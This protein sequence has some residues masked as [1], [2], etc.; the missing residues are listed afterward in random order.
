VSVAEES[1]L[2]VG[3]PEANAEARKLYKAGLRYGHAGLFLQAAELFERAV[4][5]KPDYEDAYQG[6]GHAY[7]DLKQWDKAVPTLERALALDPKDKETRDRLDLAR[8][9]LERERREGP[10]LQE[11]ASSQEPQN[12]SPSVPTI[13]VAKVSADEVSLT[14]VYRVGPGDVLDVRFGE[15]PAAESAVF[16]VTPAGLLD[17]P[18]LVEPLPV[19]GLTV[20]EISAR[21]ESAPKRPAATANAVVSVGVHDYVSHAIMVSG[22]VKDPGTKI[23]QREA[24][25][26]SV[27]VADAQPLPEAQQ[28]TVVRNQS[29]QS[30]TIDLTG[31]DMSM[32]VRP[33]DVITLQVNPT[34]FFYVS[35]EV[36]D[37]GEKV[38]RRGLTLT[39]A[40]MTAGG[41]VKKSKEVRLA[42]DDGKGFL[43]VTRYKLQD[44]ESG[45]VQDPAIQPGDRI[46]IM[47]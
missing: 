19:A 23:L 3:S 16:T 24:I 29:N 5:L 1:D 47:H 43:S 11:S 33:G 39:Q 41:L 25:P 36:K 17:H 46:T 7:F 31:A 8:S 2:P 35:G 22:L 34:Q 40:I 45:K 18:N 44:I 30:F 9:M 10:T 15:T 21:L 32:L 13:S 6:L 12:T 14:R 28:V 4:K 26:L 38:F 27:V 20:D 37:P 42:R